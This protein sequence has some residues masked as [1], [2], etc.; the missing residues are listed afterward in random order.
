MVNKMNKPNF[1]A[2]LAGFQS[3]FQHVL[4]QMRLLTMNN[5]HF[6]ILIQLAWLDCTKKSNKINFLILQTWKQSKFE[7][8]GNHGIWQIALY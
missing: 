3:T 2:Y 7:L 4:Y 8:N 1:S 5:N 6:V